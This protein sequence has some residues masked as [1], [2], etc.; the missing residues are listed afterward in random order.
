MWTYTLHFETALPTASTICGA[1]KLWLKEVVQ[2]LTFISSYWLFCWD[3]FTSVA[4]KKGESWKWCCSSWQ[5]KKIPSECLTN[6]F[7]PDLSQ[8]YFPVNIYFLIVLFNLNSVYDRTGSHW[9]FWLDSQMPC[10]Q[11]EPCRKLQSMAKFMLFFEEQNE[12]KVF[13][14]I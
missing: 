4:R 7:F 1:P 6:F 11:E 14:T 9:E 5:L 3:L 12:N 10:L 2:I 8:F 13:L